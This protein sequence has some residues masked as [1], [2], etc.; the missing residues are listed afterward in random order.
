MEL[1]DEPIQI[2]VL[3]ILLADDDKDDCNFFKEALEELP[4]SSHLTLVHDGD[5]LMQL[6]NK[7]TGPLPDALFLD[8]NMPRKNGFA[9]L[10]EIKGNN[11][12]KHLPVIILS[13]SFDENIAD[14]LYKNGAHFYICKP[15]D[16]NKLKEVIKHALALVAKNTIPTTAQRMA[17]NHKLKTN[18][19][20][21]ET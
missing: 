21:N 5:Q 9:C 16:F 11:K 14:G 18:P 13:T 12:L 8:L 19:A 7:R 10:E 4:L 1:G 20:L 6:L 2:G 17:F 3:D 15:A